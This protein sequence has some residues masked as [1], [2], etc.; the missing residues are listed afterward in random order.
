MIPSCG[1]APTGSRGEPLIYHLLEEQL[2]DDFTVIHSLP[3][4]SAAAREITGA[5]A[6]T[7]E[8]DFLIL[9]PVLGV[10]AL[11]VKGGV[12]KVEGLAFV[13]VKSGTT[14]R[15]VEQTRK[16]VHG[17][18]RWLG[19]HPG[20]RLKMGYALAFPHSDFHGLTVSTALVDVTVDPPERILIDIRDAASIGRR[21]T[22]IML[23]WKSAL[24]NPPLGKERLK[25]LIDT[26]CPSFDGT[27]TWAARVVWDREIW[28]RLTPEQSTVVN[29]AISGNRMVVTGWPGTGK[30][31]ILIE[32][33]RRLLEQGKSVLVL[34]FNSLLAKY[35]QRQIGANRRIVVRTWHSFCGRSA[36]GRN[37]KMIEL[38]R[39]WLD[40]RCLED[41]R[42]NRNSGTIPTFDAV[43]VDEAQAFRTEWIG[44]LC[45]WHANRQMLTFCDE[46][47]VF[48]FE[49]GRISLANLCAM[50]NTERAFALTSVLRSPQAVFQRLRAVRKP[51]YQLHAPR[52]LEIDALEERLVVDMKAALAKTLVSLAEHGVESSDI[53]VLNKFGWAINP[54]TENTVRFDTLSRFRGM[55]SSI[56]VISSAEDMDDVELFCAYSRATTLCIALYDAEKLGVYGASCRFQSIVLS[57]PG[58]SEIAIKA[59]RDAQTGEIVQ[60]NFETKWFD[61]ETVNLG[62][63]QEWR[64]WVVA[65]QDEM[66]AY[67]LDHLALQYSWPIYYWDFD[68]LRAV[69]KSS[70][71]RDAAIEGPGGH[72]YSLVYCDQCSALT[73][74]RRDPLHKEEVWYCALCEDPVDLMLDIP[75]NHVLEEIRYLDN[76]LTSDD[77]KS[78]SDTERKSIPLCLAAGAALQYAECNA[79]RELIGFDSVSSNRVSYHAALGF[80]YSRINLLPIGKELNVQKLAEDLFHRYRVPNGL[81][82]KIWKRDLALACSVAYKRGHLE[83]VAKG[84]YAVTSI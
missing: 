27:P 52:A 38:D 66:S 28:L 70:P 2:S 83:K 74:Q 5:K 10:L 32:C 41:L 72:P 61:L 1:P 60:A 30:T 77:P 13:H 35:I 62:W 59:R 51:D 6:V 36:D 16:N 54:P 68:S 65:L 31:L 37:V 46:T 47:Q 9:H 63:I 50:V 21:V 12:H 11:E 75:D 79:T 73:P 17:L 3:W 49:E 81:T 24:S 69:R 57:V 80:V 64:S 39:D 34:T 4:L 22:E 43:L 29:D 45:E 84:I 23:Y 33:A 15:V 26:L 40:S 56:V 18:A 76:L 53:V 48:S 71:I 78:I 58:N 82:F 55:E 20:L 67:W 19:V 14:T 44:W 7:G 42:R 8:I 25:T